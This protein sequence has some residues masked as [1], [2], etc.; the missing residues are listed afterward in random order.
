MTQ[1][2]HSFR[3][4]DQ[5]SRE[6]LKAFGFNDELMAILDLSKLERGANSTSIN[7]DAQGQATNFDLIIVGNS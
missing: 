7:Q 3:Y 1:T 5:L 4:Y 2:V 6:T